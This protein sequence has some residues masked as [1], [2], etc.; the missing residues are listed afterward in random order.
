MNFSSFVREVLPQIRP[1][2]TVVLFNMGVW[3]GRNMSA[4]RVEH[5]EWVAWREA[6]APLVAS[7]MRVVYKTATACVPMNHRVVTNQRDEAAAHQ[8]EVF[9]AHTLSRKWAGSLRNY[10]PDGVHFQKPTGYNELNQHLLEQL[11]PRVNQHTMPLPRVVGSAEATADEPPPAEVQPPA[12]LPSGVAATTASTPAPTPTNAPTPA[13]SVS[14]VLDTSTRRLRGCQT[15]PR[16][17]YH[18]SGWEQWWAAH[19]GEVRGRW[20]P[21]GCA[22]FCEGPCTIEHVVANQTHPIAAWLRLQAE[23]ETRA[24]WGD[25]RGDAGTRP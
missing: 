16:I 23:R 9:D 19:I 6:F 24:G 11:Y 5:G 3:L 13:S 14:T 15:P 17:S 25:L 7:G 4:R 22:A 8:F 1:K 20:H 10:M 21:K 12:P 2:P 18:A